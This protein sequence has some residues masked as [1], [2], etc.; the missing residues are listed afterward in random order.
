MPLRLRGDG[1]QRCS[2]KVRGA[3]RAG[4]RFL[5][6]SFT[7]VS[8]SGQLPNLPCGVLVI[9][10]ASYVAERS[11]CSTPRT[12]EL[13]VR[14]QGHPQMNRAIRSSRGCHQTR[15]RRTNTCACVHSGQEC[16]TQQ[17]IQLVLPWGINSN[18]NISKV[19]L[20]HPSRLH[21]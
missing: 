3:T 12:H 9:V 15:Q 18:P 17:T 2:S 8:A 13:L 11:V 20:V 4:R 19:L 14:G 16:M 5:F 6:C 7:C 1:P 10:A 21:L